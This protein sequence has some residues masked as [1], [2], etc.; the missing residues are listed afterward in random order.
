MIKKI[1]KF[2]FSFRKELLVW[3]QS[4]KGREREHY[5]IILLFKLNDEERTC[6]R[7][8]ERRGRIEPNWVPRPINKQI[9]NVLDPYSTSSKSILA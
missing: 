3:F 8:K 7:N 2:R 9:Y 6:R 5:L 1:N 4:N